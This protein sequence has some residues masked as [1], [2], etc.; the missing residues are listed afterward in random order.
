M[1]IDQD[2]K[3]WVIE[4][5]HNPSLSIYFDDSAG[6]DHK[7]VTDA[8][9]NQTDLYVNAR[10]VTDTIKL[11]KKS[12]SAIAE[13]DEFNSLKRILWSDAPIYSGVIALR[14]LFFE[15]APIKNKH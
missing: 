7:R 6:M 8:D 9:I 3:P 15:L 14:R 5:N 13:L 1:L 2:C 10:V 12:R 11:A 4:V